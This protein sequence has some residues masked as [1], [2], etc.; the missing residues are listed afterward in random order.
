MSYGIIEFL[1]DLESW[2]AVRRLTTEGQREGYLSNVLEEM[3]EYADGARKNNSHE[4]IDAICDMLVFSGNIVPI[5][6]LVSNEILDI[7]VPEKHTLQFLA[8]KMSAYK[9]VADTIIEGRKHE[10]VSIAL[11]ELFAICEIIA[12]E[13]GY[14]LYKSLKEVAKQINS[15]TGAGRPRKTS[16]SKTQ[17]QRHKQKSIKLI[18]LNAKYQP[19]D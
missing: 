6:S 7:P 1:L 19:T 18:L 2:R 4:K 9:R 12:K 16:G 5:S 3:A 13:D 10:E 8:K 11:Y 17:V 15:R 14:D